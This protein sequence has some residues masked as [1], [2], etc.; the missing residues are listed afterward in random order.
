MNHSPVKSSSV[1]SLAYDPQK[2]ALEVKYHGSGKTYSYEGVAY[3]VH[4]KLMT[5]KSVGKYV[6]NVI[7]KNHKAT[8]ISH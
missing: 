4:L 7:Q 1:S 6:Q 5:A 3:D 8:L 2:Q